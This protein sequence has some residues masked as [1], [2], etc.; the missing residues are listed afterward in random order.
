MSSSSYVAPWASVSL[1]NFPRCED[2]LVLND[3]DTDG[4]MAA[5][6]LPDAR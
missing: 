3:D 2:L 6:A 4:I 5:L 1:L